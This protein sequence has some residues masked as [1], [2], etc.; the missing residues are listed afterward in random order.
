MNKGQN[1]YK[2]VSVLGIITCNR[3][4]MLRKLVDS[5]DPDCLAKRIIVNNGAPLKGIYDGYEIIQSKR[6]PTPVGSGKN[7][8]IRELLKFNPNSM[9][10]LLEEDIEIMD[11]NVWEHYIDAMLDSGIIG[12]LSWPFHGALSSGNIN[13]D[14][15]LRIKA[16]AKYTKSTIDFYEQSY[17]AFTLF[18]GSVFSKVG[19]MDENFVNAGEHLDHYQRIANGK[20]GLRGVPFWWFPSVS[21]DHEWI[22]DQKQNFE[23]SAIRSQPD[24]M[25]NFGKAWQ[26]FRQ[27]HGKVPTELPRCS[28]AELM[29]KLEEIEEIYSQKNL[30]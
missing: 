25:T 23:N 18:H 24:F 11:N 3:E 17:A 26:Y 20:N 9:V 14:G 19:Y 2:D 13:P 28:Q 22:K 30:L 6:N 8:A 1:K 27:K 10:F 16:S 21:G 12:Q 4:D 7:M 5:I 29:K 15:T